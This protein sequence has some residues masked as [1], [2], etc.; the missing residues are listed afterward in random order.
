MES[1]IDQTFS[2]IVQNWNRLHTESQTQAHALISQIL[3]KH[4]ALVR[5]I[6]NTLPSLSSLPLMSKY[7]EDL[8]RL[9]AQMD[10]KHR[11]L[12]FTRRLENENVGVVHQALMELL[13]NL[14]EQQDFLH[15]T[16]VKEQP[17][18]VLAQLIRSIL[19]VATKFSGESTEVAILCSQNL[20]LIG[21]ID[22]NRIETVRE[23]RDVMLLSDFAHSEDTTEFTVFL[24]R[25][26]LVKAFLSAPNT[27]TQGFLAYAM[28]ELLKLCNMD[29]SVTF[30][31]RDT[32]SNDNYRRWVALPESVRNVLTPF[33]SSKYF[34]SVGG[35]QLTCTYP[36][37]S[38]RLS[39]EK[40]LRTFVLDLLQ[41]PHREN[42]ELLYPIFSRV[43]RG[44]DISVATFLLPF[45]ALHSILNGIETEKQEVVEELYAVLRHPLP[46]DDR[47]VADNILQCSEVSPP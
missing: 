23:D 36:L 32:Q 1:L 47:L 12:A 20:G 5:G 40:W 35:M 14:Q 24:L 42:T 7:E 8:G 26:I 30:R 27:R 37:F 2:I 3:H 43:I 28:Q 11:F 46:E 31:A 44:Q 10:V 18:R 9:R 13:P 38:T 4:Q 19:D 41:K 39:H 45:V 22:P 25:E 16:A 17:D 29:A 34:V 21:C 33:T 6:V 15:Q